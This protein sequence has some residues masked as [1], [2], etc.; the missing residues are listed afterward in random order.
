M[1]KKSKNKLSGYTILETMISIALFLVVV[2]FGM[3]TLLNAN[4]VSHK[5]EDLRSIM[6]NLS[7][8]MEDM[9]KNLR[10]GNS[11][12]CF[13]KEIETQVTSGDLGPPRSC[14]DGWA[15]AFEPSLGNPTIYTDQWIYALDTEGQIWKSVNGAQTFSELTPDE[16]VVDQI[17]GFSVL[18]APPVSDG[19][20]QQQP[21]V[22]I[23]LVGSI[24]YKNVVTPFS[25]QTSVS[26]R[27]IENY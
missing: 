6:D 15:I 12:Q 13:R 21:L 20:D 4:L 3:D 19:L 16:V 2:M 10:T 25:L 18:G 24:T 14:E 9:S 26:Q 17:S 7:F 11:F 8:I 5:T 22:V 23:K 1:N 27:L